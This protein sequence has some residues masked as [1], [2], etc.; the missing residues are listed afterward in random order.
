M[1]A[2]FKIILFSLGFIGMFLINKTGNKAYFAPTVIM[3]IIALIKK[4]MDARGDKP[5]FITCILF[6]ILS[7]FLLIDIIHPTL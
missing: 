3:I 1:S 6:L 2:K 4:A 5:I 7:V